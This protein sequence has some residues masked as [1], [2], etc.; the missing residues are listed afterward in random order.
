[1]ST[2]G[3]MVSNCRGLSELLAPS[4]KW[5]LTYILHK[6]HEFVTN[7]YLTCPNFRFF[8]NVIL[9]QLQHIVAS[10]QCGEIFMDWK[11][12]ILRKVNLGQHTYSTLSADCFEHFFKNHCSFSSKINCFVFLLGPPQSTRDYYFYRLKV[13]IW[14]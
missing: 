10:T 14:P 3:V 7:L 12:S 1:M 2:M 6:S 11:L 4:R 9:I 13:F 5:E 8:I